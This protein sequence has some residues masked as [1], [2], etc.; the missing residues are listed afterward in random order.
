M[1]HRRKTLADH[2]RHT[3]N[4]GTPLLSEIELTDLQRRVEDDKKAIY[5]YQKAIIGYYDGYRATQEI[6][7]ALNGSNKP[8]SAH[9]NH[10][11]KRHA[12]TLAM[13]C[14]SFHAFSEGNYTRFI[15][16]LKRN[17]RD[18][19]QTLREIKEKYNFEFLK[20]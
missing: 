14:A 6:L 2:I 20:V 17:G 1:K 16:T 19:E 10:E 12:S 7:D 15:K 18:V 11:I 9:Y 5:S 4:H 3:R 8:E 13:K